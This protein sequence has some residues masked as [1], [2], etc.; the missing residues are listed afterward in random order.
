VPLTCSA[1]FV[2]IVGPGGI[3]KTALALAVAHELINEFGHDLICFIDLGL[4][5]EDADVV[6]AV[7][8]A[9]G[10]VVQGPDP[11]PY[12]LAF[13]KDRRFLIV[14]DNCEHLVGIVTT[15]AE[16][17]IRK[18][19]TLYL[20]ATSREALRAQGENIYHLTPLRL[21]SEETVS[22]EDALQT[23]AIQ[24]FM[25]KAAASGHR[26]ELSDIDALIVSDICRQLDGI[27]LAIELV[28]SHVGTYGIRGT[29]DLLKSGAEL[30]LRGRRSASPRH[31]TLYSMLDWSFSLL[32]KEEKSVL[33]RLSAFAGHFSLDAAMAIASQHPDDGLKVARTISALIEKSLISVSRDF[34][35][36]A[37]RLLDTTRSYATAQLIASG[38]L[39]L[40]SRRHAVYFSE[41]LRTVDIVPSYHD[42]R[43]AAAYE[44]HLSN[45]RKALAWSFS[46][47][48]DRAVGVDLAIRSAPVFLS[49]SSFTESEKWCRKA[50]ETEHDIQPSAHQ[51]LALQMSIAISSLYKHGNRDEVRVAIDRGL[52]LS[53]ALQGGRRHFDFLS[54]LHTYLVRRGDFHG[55]VHI[56][57][58]SALVAKANHDPM[59]MAVAEWM[60]AAAIHLT[61]NQLAA[62]S[63]CRRGFTFSSGAERKNAGYFGY[64]HRLI[65]LVTIARAMWITGFVDQGRKAA[66]EAMDG[67]RD[68]D[69]P[70]TFC[71]AL[72][73]A[74]CVLI[75]SGDWSHA[76][77]F[78]EAV[79]E[80]AER[81]SLAP[82]RAVGTALKGEVMIHAG[83]VASG[84]ALV[85]Q[86]VGALGRE[87]YHIIRS[88]SHCALALGLKRLGRPEDA[89]ALI[90][91]A[92][93]RAETVGEKLWL[94]ELL[95][96]RGELLLDMPRPD[97]DGIEQILMTSID[98]ARNQSALSWELRSAMS[99]A[100]LQLKRGRRAQA[101]GTLQQPLQKFSEGFGTASLIAAQRLFDELK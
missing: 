50:L 31:H 75:W 63:H 76:L 21:P 43:D 54:G 95:R 77:D 83:D 52:E 36:A 38:E 20:L 53:Q 37:Y 57:E 5:V 79:I 65:G 67:A 3:G 9:L 88:S 98:H 51:E 11:E 42:R 6:G 7:A 41:L 14:L 2:T 66:L 90:D 99:L 56:A 25:E 69:H 87:N 33:I 93:N 92:L 49:L 17:L 39:D 15:F 58:Q 45:I 34:G 22:A 40:I 4:L 101:R 32:S 94:P 60:T 64:D 91:D 97:L 35:A 71:I 80:R 55:A 81:Y 23:P 70:I 46:E 48:G 61:G 100:Q 26:A 62:L 10:C 72:L 85:R 68:L 29:A 44:P 84:V 12:V 8:S 89:A 13:L 78:S 19:P 82:Y 47:G 73:H 28:A 16:R 74:T 24:L 1:R 86:A 18:T 96:I 30:S 59:E 27:A